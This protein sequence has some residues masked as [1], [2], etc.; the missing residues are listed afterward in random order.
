MERCVWAKSNPLEMYHHDH[1]W[2]VP[3]H[4]GRLLFEML[5]LESAQSGLSWAT[6]EK[7]E[8]GI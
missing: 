5:I 1:E 7:N 8:K 2:A 6:P 4:D 3:V